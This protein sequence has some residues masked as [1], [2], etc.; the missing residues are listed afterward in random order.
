MIKALNSILMI[1]F[2]SSPL[3][4][5]T[6]SLV[7]S[8]VTFVAIG[9]PGFL[10]INGKGAQL[11]G[12]LQYTGRELTGELLVPMNQFVTG[13]E[14]RDDHMKKTYFE[15]DKYPEAQ[16]KI[17]KVEWKEKTSQKNLPFQ[18]LLS[19]HG[20]EKPVEGTVD[21]DVEQTK[22]SMQAR[23]GLQLSD[24]KIDIPSYAGVKVADKVEVKAELSAEERP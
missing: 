9:K 3:L 21:I 17:T 7:D 16:L 22:F 4:G 8:Q 12:S 1:L 19:F 18:G 20:L 24:Y 5:G 15:V 11:K 10:K 13:I 14:L 23:F 2:T 6:L